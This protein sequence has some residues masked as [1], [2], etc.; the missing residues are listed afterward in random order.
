MALPSKLGPIDRHIGGLLGSITSYGVN[1]DAVVQQSF[2]GAAAPG[3]AASLALAATEGADTAAMT[4]GLAITTT[5]A[6][7]EGADTA[8]AAVGLAITTSLAATE[9]ADTSAATVNL[10]VSVALAATEGADTLA[11]SVDVVAG[12]SDLALDATE[13]ADVLAAVMDREV[14]PVAPPVA[15][16]PYP[17]RYQG[18]TKPLGVIGRLA[19]ERQLA[20]DNQEI[21]IAITGLRSETITL[22]GEGAN[23]AIVGYPVVR[24]LKSGAVVSDSVLQNG[25]FVIRVDDLKPNWD[26]IAFIKSGSSDRLVLSIEGQFDYVDAR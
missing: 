9:G 22:A 6:I 5:M 15:P 26:S 7:T 12:S 4:V 1:A 20:E 23:G 21:V 2:F 18:P 16:T 11:A 14:D 17:D 3:G 25:V 24:H 19:I 13:G 8:S 10:A